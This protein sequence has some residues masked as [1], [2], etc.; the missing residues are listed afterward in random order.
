MEDGFKI[1]QFC[2]EKIRKEAVKCRFCGEWLEQNEN[3]G[4]DIKI[5]EDI[6]SRTSQ[7]HEPQSSVESQNGIASQR[8]IRNAISPKTLYWISGILLA[9]CG[10][11]ICLG[12]SGGHWS[13]STPGERSYAIT[14]MV[15]NL[16]MVLVCAGVFGLRAKRKGYGLF[17]F[18][19]ACV[20]FTA[21]GFYYFLDARQKAQQKMAASDR[22]LANDVNGLQEFFKN[23]AVGDIPQF[24]PSGEAEEDALLQ[25]FNDF[26]RNY[27]QAFRKVNVEFQTLDESDVFGDLFL[28]NKSSLESEIRKRTTGQLAIQTFA[29]NALSMI[30]DA[31]A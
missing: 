11:V 14:K 29:T 5:T 12:L 17:A 16:I 10:F 27:I 20:I 22:Q 19:I 7:L 25:T 30:E 2:K 8:K 21:I 28:T 6:T 26:Y 13:Q 23:G 18:S 9:I 3:V 24:R 1:C 15:V 31:S 4:V